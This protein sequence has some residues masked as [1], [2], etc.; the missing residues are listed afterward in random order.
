MII[1]I[2]AQLPPSL[3]RWMTDSFGVTATPIRNLA[4]REAKDPEIFE[5]ARAAN[6]VVMTKDAD[7]VDLARRLGS[8]P[9]VLW[10]TCGNTSNRH[11][12]EILSKQLQNAI[13]LLR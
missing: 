10:V 12:R 8:P 2:D 4:L 6:A 7:F 11:L 13:Q 3:A 1:W 5:A 9:Q